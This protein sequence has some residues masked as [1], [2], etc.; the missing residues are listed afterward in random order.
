M[1][2]RPEHPEPEIKSAW[3]LD[4]WARITEGIDAG[5]PRPP[6]S[7]HD[8]PAAPQ[9]AGAQQTPQRSL[10]SRGTGRLGH[11]LIKILPGER[12]LIPR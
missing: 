9:A 8:G 2:L 6:G 5:W 11:E 4:G 7:V 10:R 12:Q 1:T 3:A